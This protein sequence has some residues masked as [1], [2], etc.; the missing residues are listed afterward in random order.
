[1][2]NTVKKIL[3][4]AI[5]MAV[6]LS[7]LAFV[8]V[9]ATDDEAVSGLILNSS[10]YFIDFETGD[11]AENT[12]HFSKYHGEVSYAIY[13]EGAGGSA[14]SLRW[15][16]KNRVSNGVASTALHHM[17]KPNGAS[18]SFTVPAGY[19]VKYSFKLK[20]AQPLTAGHI[21]VQTIVNSGSGNQYPKIW[22]T[23]F[24]NNETEKW[25]NISFV[26]TNTGSTNA[27]FSIGELLFN[28]NKDANATTTE[29]NYV[30][31]Y[32]PATDETPADYGTRSY[33][34][35]DIEFGLFAP[36]AML[37]SNV[38]NTANYENYYVNYEN[39]PTNVLPGAT[40]ANIFYL[41]SATDYA[42]LADI[43]ANG[44]GHSLKVNP[45]GSTAG[46]L[47]MKTRAGNIRPKALKKGDV[48]TVA[49]DLKLGSAVSD[50]EIATLLRDSSKWQAYFGDTSAHYFSGLDKTNTKSWQHFELTFTAEEDKSYDMGDISV[51]F[52]KEGATNAGWTFVEGAADP[53]VYIDNLT[54]FIDRTAYPKTGVDVTGISA[55]CNAVGQILNVGYTFNPSAT[56]ATDNSIIRLVAK[57][58]NG[59]YSS[60]AST[61]AGNAIIVPETAQGKDLY[62]EVIA[63]DSTGRIGKTY[64]IA[65]DSSIP[66]DDGTTSS[67]NGVTVAFNDVAN[68][69]KATIRIDGNFAELYQGVS[70]VKFI[71]TAYDAN[72]KMIGSDIQSVDTVAG[73]KKTISLVGVDYTQVA[74]LKCFVW[75]DD[76]KL[77]PVKDAITRLPAQK[78]SCWGDSLTQG[79]RSEGIS[80][81]IAVDDRFAEYGNITYG[82]VLAKLSG[83]TINNYGCGGDNVTSIAC[84]QGGLDMLIGTGFIIPA[85]T[86]TVDIDLNAENGIFINTLFQAPQNANI[87]PVVINGVEGTLSVVRH[88]NAHQLTEGTFHY[89]FTR[90]T[91]GEEVNVSAG[92][93]VIPASVREGEAGYAKK[94][95]V[96][97]FMGANRGYGDS[98][99]SL[100]GILDSMI[101]NL[102]YENKEYVIVCWPHNELNDAIQRG[103]AFEARYGNRVVN[104]TK[105]FRTDVEATFEKYGFT[106][107]DTDRADLAKENIP[108]SLLISDGMH[109]NAVGNYIL[110]CEIYEKMLELGILTK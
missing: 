26:Y 46:K 42:S 53:Y 1:M 106:L 27:T 99:E 85:D 48:L 24:D 6:M 38:S 95:I 59:S 13:N 19:S 45:T 25:Q 12:S 105:I 55:R 71:I 86:T 21:S 3:S 41:G 96:V 60:L 108:S 73:T 11:Y 47:L 97:L 16:E 74:K 36:E 70:S 69:P 49:F 75:S 52:Y 2:I 100:F 80:N 67:E 37:S 93:K 72:G 78:I 83:K 56:G 58:R 98:F 8:P 84:R 35:D 103:N 30:I 15:T 28:N 5:V 90:S 102:D 66:E 109:F 34:F 62:L 51:H 101:E 29:G 91:A 68:I 23:T 17:F 57:D 89:A 76:G 82:E 64:R 110:G 63:G 40:N 4:L 54:M 39:M 10:Y 50:G 87:N 104:L 65:V 14:R 94:D 81:V 107:T 77:V 7:L 33:Y 32:T 31:G 20:L 9:S 44:E 92:T 43:S 79:D 88:D 61:T 18:P 22:Y